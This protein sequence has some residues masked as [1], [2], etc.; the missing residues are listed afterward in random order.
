MGHALFDLP[1][2]YNRSTGSPSY[3]SNM[4]YWDTQDYGLYLSTG[5]NP[6]PGYSAFSRMLCGW[7]TP[8]LLTEAQHCKLSPLTET[9][10]CYMIKDTETHYYL[11]EN[12]RAVSGSWDN[13]LASGLIVTEVNEN[14]INSWIVNHGSNDGKV[15][16]LTANKMT[17]TS[18]N[19]GTN[20]ASQP[21]GGSVKSI[22]SSYGSTF[23]TKTVTNITLNSDGTIEFDY[24]SEPDDPGTNTDGK[25][26]TASFNDWEGNSIGFSDIEV[27]VEYLGENKYVL[28]DFVGAGDLTVELGAESGGYQDVTFSSTNGLTNDQYFYFDADGNTYTASNGEQVGLLYSS[29]SYYYTA[30]RWLSLCYWS[31]SKSAWNYIEMVLPEFDEP[32]DPDE[33]D[34]PGYE[35]PDVTFHTEGTYERVGSMDEVVPGEFYIIVSGGNK[36][37]RDDNGD[38]F[39]MYPANVSTTNHTYTGPVNAGDGTP[40]EFYLQAADPDDDYYLDY[41]QMIGDQYYFYSHEGYLAFYP[42]GNYTATGYKDEPDPFALSWTADG[43]ILM[44]NCSSYDSNGY[45]VYSLTYEKG[46]DYE[47]FWVSSNGATNSNVT[48]YRYIEPVE[49]RTMAM[50]SK[51]LR[52]EETVTHYDACYKKTTTAPTQGTEFLIVSGNTYWAMTGEQGVSV[53]GPGN[54][55]YTGEVNVEGK[56]YTFTLTAEGYLQCS[57]GLYVNRSGNNLTFD[58]AGST[59]WNFYRSGSNLRL[60]NGSRNPY[61]Y[62]CN[63]TAEYGAFTNNSRSQDYNLSIYVMSEAEDV[64]TTEMVDAYPVEFSIK[65]PYATLYSEDAYMMPGTDLTGYF[66]PNADAKGGEIVPTEV[67]HSGD[68]VPAGTALLLTGSEGD[69]SAVAYEE[70]ASGTIKT[71]A[72]DWDNLLEGT[73]DAAGMTASSRTNVYYYK[74]AYN[75]AGT[76]LGFY[77]G[78]EDG[79][80]FLMTRATSAYLAVDRDQAAGVKGFRLPGTADG[81][82]RV[83]TA[84]QQSTYTLSGVRIQGEAPLAP[85]IYVRGGRKIVVR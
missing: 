6:V 70:S 84:D 31:E 26:T 10:Q 7:L 25:A 63:P 57:N 73:R 83:E 33:P 80:P 3:G 27:V 2:Y 21:F 16:I 34:E 58:E 47:D 53:P 49:G 45:Y 43:N 46:S 78:A 18:S 9:A 8:T 79:A 66:V 67:Y 75:Q 15:K 40:R 38:G 69:Y 24:G 72:Y 4:G 19:Y 77:W 5:T 29:Y 82:Q 62:F 39:Y 32:T 59:A 12:R 11:L 71:Y 48:L 55:R 50:M 13:G 30:S 14:G 23:A 35:A 81:I 36:A 22:D 85:G 74:L 20:L 61:Y 41:P 64:T 42:S 65:A 51:K 28:K 37:L 44:R 54:E 1:D 60:R 17:F 76:T 52:A 68:I 56:P